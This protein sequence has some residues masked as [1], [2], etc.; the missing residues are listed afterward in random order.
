MS[1][2]TIPISLF[3]LSSSSSSSSSQSTSLPNL[4]TFMGIYQQ[5]NHIPHLEK[6]KTLDLTCEPVYDSRLTTVVPILKKLTRLTRLDIWMHVVDI[7]SGRSDQMT[8]FRPVFSFPSLSTWVQTLNMWILIFDYKVCMTK[9][10]YLPWLHPLSRLTLQSFESFFTPY[11]KRK[12]PD[13]IA[14]LLNGYAGEIVAQLERES[15]NF[16]L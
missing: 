3:S 6:I 16:L 10:D 2:T 8:G 1:P 4:D 11:A 9:I 13:R 12:V 14:I 7:R 5:L 15:T